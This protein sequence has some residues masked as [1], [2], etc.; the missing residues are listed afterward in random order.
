MVQAVVRSVA[1]ASAVA[2][3]WDPGLDRRYGDDE[4]VRRLVEG[5][6]AFCGLREDRP[7]VLVW[8][9]DR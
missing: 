1:R 3:V 7:V 8:L 4:G 9:R 2:R 5:L 6:G